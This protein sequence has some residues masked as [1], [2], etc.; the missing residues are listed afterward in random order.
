MKKPRK[1]SANS[2]DEQLFAC[3]GR[4]VSLLKLSDGASPSRTVIPA[5]KVARIQLVHFLLV[6]ILS[7]VG[8]VCCVA[9]VFVYPITWVEPCLFIGM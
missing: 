3:M 9:L 2:I 6:Y 7:F 5:E 4:A 8:S 1:E